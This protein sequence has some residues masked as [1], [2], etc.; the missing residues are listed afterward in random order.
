MQ[1]FSGGLVYEFSQE[2]NNYGLVEILPN[3]DV[4]LLDDYLSLKE[5]LKKV[6]ELDRDELL[7]GMRKNVSS[8]PKGL[9]TQ[10][11]KLPECSDSYKSLDVSRRLP[12]PV[13]SIYLASRVQ[14][15]QGKYIQMTEADLKSP[16]MVFDTDG[17]LVY[18]D[19]PTVQRIQDTTSSWTSARRKMRGLHNCT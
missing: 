4:R 14:V 10:L 5:Q 9:K 3:N 15:E 16:Y 18:M 13:G 2:P 11:Q 19:K 12:K 7:S 1:V 6:P 17:R 8:I